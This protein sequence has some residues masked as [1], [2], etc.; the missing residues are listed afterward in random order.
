MTGERPRF[1][2]PGRTDAGVHALAMAPMLTSMKPLTAYR[3][4]KG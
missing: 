3:L 1:M 4:R 2:P